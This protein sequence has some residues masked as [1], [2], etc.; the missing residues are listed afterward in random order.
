MSALVMNVEKVTNPTTTMF[1]MVNGK[2]EFAFK[3]TELREELKANR[4]K[5]LNKFGRSEAERYLKQLRNLFN[6]FLLIHDQR[7][8]RGD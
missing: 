6:L 2:A 5:F 3:Q 7:K 8:I 4:S 1:G